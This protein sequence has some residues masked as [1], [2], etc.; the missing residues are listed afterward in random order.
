MDQDGPVSGKFSTTEEGSMAEADPQTLPE[1]IEA[2]PADSMHQ[3][4]DT[5]DV[6]ADPLHGD[7]AK[8]MLGEDRGAGDVAA[9]GMSEEVE[10]ESRALER[11]TEAA[12]AEGHLPQMG[13]LAS[14]DQVCMASVMTSA[15]CVRHAHLD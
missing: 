11:G 9:N 8:A 10:A 6:I 5:E 3:D 13:V 7:A 14:L 1:Q 2:M 12:P 15:T 4:V